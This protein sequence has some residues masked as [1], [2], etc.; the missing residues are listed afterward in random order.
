MPEIENTKNMMSWMLIEDHCLSRC[1]RLRR[2]LKSVKYAK[3]QKQNFG[4]RIV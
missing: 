2:F 1:L 3:L 4:L